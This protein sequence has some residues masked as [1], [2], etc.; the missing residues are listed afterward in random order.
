MT[1]MSSKK[2]GKTSPVLHWE[3]KMAP[4]GKLNWSGLGFGRTHFAL[5]GCMLAVG[6]L[7]LALMGIISVVRPC[8]GGAL[9]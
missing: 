3:A 8:P 9:G 1:A 7:R 5:A 4:T 6:R 2:P